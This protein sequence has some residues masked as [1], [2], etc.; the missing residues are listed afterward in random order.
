MRIR[1][2]SLGSRWRDW[3]SAPVRWSAARSATGVRRLDWPTPMCALPRRTTGARFRVRRWYQGLV[4]W[5]REFTDCCSGQPSGI[6]ATGRPTVLCLVTTSP[7]PRPGRGSAQGCSVPDIAARRAK[8]RR[9]DYRGYG[10]G[11]SGGSHV[12][13]HYQ[14]VFVTPETGATRERRGVLPRCGAQR[15]EVCGARCWC[16]RRSR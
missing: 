9:R 11:A 1:D 10:P 4:E 7:F 15:A 6:A 3:A 16:L 12:T 5:R 2:R 14:S 13:S 8:L